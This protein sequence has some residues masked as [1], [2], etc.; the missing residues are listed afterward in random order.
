MPESSDRTQTLTRYLRRRR[1]PTA[2][3][4]FALDCPAGHTVRG[5]R[6]SR[7]QRVPCP[8]CGRTVFVFP[9]SPFPPP[10]PPAPS[11]AERKA[12]KTR[13]RLPRVRVRLRRSRRTAV[14]K[15]RRGAFRLVPPRR[16]FTLRRLVPLGVLLLLAFTVVM[17][18]RS[19]HRGSLR[20][21]FETSFEQGIDALEQG[22]FEAAAEQLGA[23][24]QA[25]SRLGLSPDE[26]HGAV[27]AAREAALCRDLSP[28]RLDQI[29]RQ[30]AEDT[31]LRGRESW[32]RS[33]GTLYE[34]QSIVFD[35]LVFPKTFP[36]RVRYDLDFLLVQ[37]GRRF[38]L[39]ARD[40]ALLIELAPPSPQ[41]VVFGARLAAVEPSSS[42]DRWQIGLAP[43]SGVLFTRPEL[44]KQLGWKIDDELK[45]V[46]EAQRKW[47]EDN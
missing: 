16:W 36:D 43:D 8:E 41:R 34:G 10:S 30:A 27:H 31:A 33:F 9:A 14:A 40:L 26:S 39:D 25:V 32:E 19:K 17:T 37:D 23:A 7:S 21:D 47:V 15:L 13:A 24:A 28:S 5:V 45:S 4:P 18:A 42:A 1:R 22:D 20:N 2:N 46:V 35:G 6:L 12:A 3:P 38:E 11:R 29:A 44:L